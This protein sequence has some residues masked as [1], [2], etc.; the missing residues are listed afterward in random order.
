VQLLPLAVA[1]FAVATNDV[2]LALK[3][4]SFVLRR[5]EREAW[6]QANSS[7]DRQP[8]IRIDVGHGPADRLSI[9]DGVRIIG[10]A[11]RTNKIAPEPRATRRAP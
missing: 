9:A 6:I 1:T 3:E 4:R 7:T 11:R 5:G 10:L 8:A 2:N